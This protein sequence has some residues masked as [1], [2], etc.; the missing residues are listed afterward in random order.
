MKESNRQ[1]KFSKLIQ[2]ELSEILQWE[3]KAPGQPMLTVSVVR[4][5]PDL[6]VCKIYV[7]VFPDAQ[8]DSVLKWFGT[9]D[10]EIR[11]HL[12]RRIRK[13]VRYV[14]ELHFYI[15][16]TLQEVEAMDDLFDQLKKED[17]QRESGQED[18]PAVAEESKPENSE[19]KEEQI[20]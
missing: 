11:Q 5:S 2:K 16:D 7:S 20:H 14:P 13:Q 15:D 10:W 3:L 9:N 6:R 18:D 4:S 8:Q 1:K 17:H 19:G 12:A